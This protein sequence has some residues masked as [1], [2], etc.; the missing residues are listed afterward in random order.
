MET[1]TASTTTASWTG[2]ATFQMPEAT[3]LDGR[4]LYRLRAF[5]SRVATE[6]YER[7]VIDLSH[8]RILP[9]GFAQL[10]LN[11][12][13]SG[14]EVL[15][16]R[17]RSHVRAMVWFRLFARAAGTGVWRM[18]NEPAFEFPGASASEEED[19]DEECRERPYS[20]FGAKARFSSAAEAVL[21]RRPR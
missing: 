2:A 4:S 11:W 15:L 9:A 10:L 20:G 21:R 16:A 14:I 13:E 18:T 6:G 5:A 19:G 3:E 12:Q 8:A 1:V 17:P 7:V